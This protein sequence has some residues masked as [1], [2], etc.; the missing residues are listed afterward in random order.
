MILE[1]AMLSE[2]MHYAKTPSAIY[3]MISFMWLCRKG[4]PMGQKEDQWLPGTEDRGTDDPR[5][6]G[7]FGRWCN[8]PYL[9]CGGGHT[10]TFG[11]PNSQ[12]FTLNRENFIVC[13][14]YLHK[15]KAAHVSGMCPT[16]ICS[17][18]GHSVQASIS[19]HPAY[20]YPSPLNFSSPLIYS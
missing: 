20:C 5:G 18:Q 6:T 19:S 3:H 14:V 11:C 16:G 1:R 17:C 13:K 9:D 10:M 2:R 7:E 8:V 12:N 4:K 15:K